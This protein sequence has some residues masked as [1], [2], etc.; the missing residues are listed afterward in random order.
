MLEIQ[1]GVIVIVA[2]QKANVPSKGITAAAI[3]IKRCD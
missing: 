3:Y 2:K 1:E